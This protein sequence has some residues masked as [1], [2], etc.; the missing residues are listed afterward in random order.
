MIEEDY[1]YEEFDE[2]PEEMQSML[3]AFARTLVGQIELEVAQQ[4]LTAV[5]DGN[6]ALI[7][8]K[9][10]ATKDTK[11]NISEQMLVAYCRA[12]IEMERR[13]IQ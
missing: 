1:D 3:G 6:A 13:T 9:Q 8:D 5:K 11:L 10:F 4:C 12:V 2:L 7:S